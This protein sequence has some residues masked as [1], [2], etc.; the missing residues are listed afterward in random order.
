MNASKNKGFFED[1]FEGFSESFMLPTDRSDGGTFESQMDLA[2]VGSIAQGNGVSDD[3]VCFAAFAYALS[4]FSGGSESVF[5]LSGD[6]IRVPV[7]LG[8]GD[9]PVEEFLK[10]AS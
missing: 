3:S 6:G 1:M 4:R 7:R 10:E 5:V 2:L 8:C 9:R